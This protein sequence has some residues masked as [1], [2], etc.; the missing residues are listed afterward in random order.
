MPH[1][2]FGAEKVQVQV[3]A[4]VDVWLSMFPD[5]MADFGEKWIVVKQADKDEKTGNVVSVFYHIRPR[6]PEDP[7]NAMLV[8]A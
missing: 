1:A 2:Q 5:D 6:K 4:F 3:Q 7:F 8:E